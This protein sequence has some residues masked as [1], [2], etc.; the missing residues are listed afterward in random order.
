M[1]HNSSTH[2]E[3]ADRFAVWLHAFWEELRRQARTRDFY[4]EWCCTVLSVFGAYSLAF[5]SGAQAQLAAWGAWLVANV[6][7]AIFAWRARHYGLLVQFVIFMPSSLAGI[8]RSL[9]IS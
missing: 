6:V 7:G 2:L 9:N 1:N 4:I 3:A 8:H 5:G